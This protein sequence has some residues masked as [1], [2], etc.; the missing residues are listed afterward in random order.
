MEGVPVMEGQLPQE[1]ILVMGSESH[2]ISEKV[3]KQ[4]LQTL[5]I[6]SHHGHGAESLNVG[7]ATAILLYELRRRK[8]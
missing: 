7:A 8:L 1:G 2:G 5:A 3:R 6:P 4:L